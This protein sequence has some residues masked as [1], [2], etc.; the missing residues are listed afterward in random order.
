MLK[1][2]N[3]K[4]VY[5][6]AGIKKTI[7]DNVSLEIKPGEIISLTG[8][9][10]S[11]KTT[12]L[13]I[14]SGLTVP[15]LGSVYICGRKI[16]YFLDILPAR[17]RNSKIGFVF[18]TFRLMPDETTWSNI[19]LPA[20]IHGVIG[21]KTLEYADELL[22]KLGLSEYKYTRAALLSGGQKQRAAIARA[23]IN[24]PELIL[25]DEPTANLDNET[26]AEIYGFLFDFARSGKSVLV[27]THSDYMLSHSE[28][29]YSIN[30]GILDEVRYKGR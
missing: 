3:I 16:T 5:R 30:N 28:R 9:S 14:I 11:G 15:T 23:F 17:M 25:A 19:L 18:Q 4:K 27:V 7:L 1:L 12:L 24:K 22:K 29:I 2:E 6:I 26:A 20:R 13:N 21:C 8:K 10:G